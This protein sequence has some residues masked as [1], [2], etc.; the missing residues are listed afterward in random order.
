[1]FSKV[2]IVFFLIKSET[3]FLVQFLL[4]L[5]LYTLDTVGILIDRYF[6]LSLLFQGLLSS[7]LVRFLF[8]SAFLKTAIKDSQATADISHSTITESLHNQLDD[9]SSELDL[10]LDEQQ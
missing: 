1:M 6:T 5:A 7:L 4:A 3:R 8:L 2:Q 10:A 9:L